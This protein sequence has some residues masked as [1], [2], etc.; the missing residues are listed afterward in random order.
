MFCGSRDLDKGV[1]DLQMADVGAVNLCR[2]QETTNPGLKLLP[3]FYDL[4]TSPID[5]SWIVAWENMQPKSDGTSSVGSNRAAISIEKCK[6]ALR[7]L[8]KSNGLVL[9][10][11]NSL[12]SL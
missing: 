7:K 10:N 8:K 6:E 1:R 4:L 12:E 3:V 5:D 11:E 2:A 9:R